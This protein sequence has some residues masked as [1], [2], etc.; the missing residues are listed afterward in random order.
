MPGTEFSMSL[1]TLIAAIGERPD[2]D[3]LASMGV[4]LD[5]GGKPCVHPEILSTSR[6]GVFAGGDLVTG[7]NTVVD[8]VAAGRRAAT[9]IDRYLL[10]EE[11]RQPGKITLPEVFVEPS[12]VTDEDLAEAAR[13]EPLTLPAES[14]KKSFAEV[15]MTLSVEEATREARRCLRCDL[16]FTRHENDDANHVVVNRNSP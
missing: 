13:V 7:P 6:Q 1:N 3:C 8:A 2:S 10:G 14:R 11:L 12:A 16:E 9:V 4:D 15:E 5:K